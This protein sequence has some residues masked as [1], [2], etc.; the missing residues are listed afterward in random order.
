[1]AQP[2]DGVREVEVHAAAAGA[3]AT[4]IVAGF[5][6]GARRDVARAQVAEARILPLEEI[7]AIVFGDLI[8]K[9][10]DILSLLWHP[11]APVVPK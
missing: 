2:L 11:D 3:H 6:G 7:V 9:L 1:L 8:R 5:L 4:P 10:R